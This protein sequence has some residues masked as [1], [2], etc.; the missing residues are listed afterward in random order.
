MCLVNAYKPVC[1][2]N[3]FF[4]R[5][6]NCETHRWD[7]CLIPSRA[8]DLPLSSMR[9]VGQ[10]TLIIFV[11]GYLVLNEEKNNQMRSLLTNALPYPI[12]GFC[13]VLFF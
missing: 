6:R 13:F 2:V 12:T 9:V 7:H 11:N 4:V 1:K 3:G 8:N 10:N 5:W